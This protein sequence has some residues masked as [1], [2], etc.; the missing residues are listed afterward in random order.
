MAKDE[1]PRSRVSLTYP[2]N[3]C[4]PKEL[5]TFIW[6]D[7]YEESFTKLELTDEEQRAVET[8]LMM[9]PEISPVMAN[10]GG[11]R[12][13]Q[14]STPGNGVGSLHLSAFYAYFPESGKV[15]LI[16]LALT[17]EMLPMTDEER[18]ELKQLFTESQ[19]WLTG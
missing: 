2:K 13:F 19:E 1:P 14:F 11:I 12:E 6:G 3:L 7:I 8:G 5:L 15:M 16:D 9:D 18:A 17:D 10:T 4:S